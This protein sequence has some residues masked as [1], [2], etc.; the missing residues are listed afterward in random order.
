MS[1]T[2]QTDTGIRLTHNEFEGRAVFG[3][4]A[5]NDSDNADNADNEGHGT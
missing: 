5:V 1:L 3:F 4:N 2:C